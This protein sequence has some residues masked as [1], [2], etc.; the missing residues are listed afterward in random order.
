MN[1]LKYFCKK[2]RYL[3][4]YVNIMKML[5]V[6]WCSRHCFTYSIKNLWIQWLSLILQSTMCAP[7]KLG[8]PHRF[9]APKRARF[10]PVSLCQNKRLL[11]FPDLSVICYAYFVEIFKIG[12]YIFL[13]KLIQ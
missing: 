7:E 6:R 13:K 3:I 10:G 11:G 9:Y 2:V 1:V 5:Q 8:S 12:F 4:R